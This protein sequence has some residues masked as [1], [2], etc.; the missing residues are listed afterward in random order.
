MY[1]LEAIVEPRY[2]NSQSFLALNELIRTCMFLENI[3][4]KLDEASLVTSLF[5][6]Q[7]LG[8]VTS[9]ICYC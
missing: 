7:T 1:I 9:L 3:A 8:D 2:N 5:P 4:F 6:V